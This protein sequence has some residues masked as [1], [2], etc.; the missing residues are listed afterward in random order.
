MLHWGK[1]DGMRSH[2]PTRPASVQLLPRRAVCVIFHRRPPTVCT[3]AASSALSGPVQD[4]LF[5]HIFTDSLVYRNPTKKCFL[6][7]PTEQPR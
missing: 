6:K 3:T 5:L 4:A 2:A 1:Q 7:R